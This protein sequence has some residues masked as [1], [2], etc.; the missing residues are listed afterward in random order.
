M[1][2]LPL[3]ENPIKQEVGIL[4]EQDFLRRAK[5]RAVDERRPLSDLIQDALER[6]L[7]VGLP[8]HR[9]AVFLLFCERPIK[10]SP[11]Q[12]KAVLERDA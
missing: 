2:L 3:K 9:E 12:F 1:C 8:E 6:Y 5:R 4:L 10:L 11:D 7:T